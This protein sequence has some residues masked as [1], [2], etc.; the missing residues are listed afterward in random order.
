MDKKFLLAITLSLGVWILW[1][2]VFRPAPPQQPPQTAPAQQTAPAPSAPV[3]QPAAATAAVSPGLRVEQSTAASEAEVS[4]ST[5]IYD[6]TFTSRGGSIK[7]FI[8]KYN[9][10]RIE[11]VVEK[12]ALDRY[13]IKADTMLDMG[14]FQSESEFNESSPLSSAIWDMNRS[15]DNAVVFSTVLK[16]Q[17]GGGIKIEKHYSFQAGASHFNL[18]Y[19]LQ[20]IGRSPIGIPNNC[21]IVGTPDFLGPTMDFNNTY[22]SLSSIY[23]LDGSF[24]RGSQGGGL[25]SNE[26]E[27]VR[28]RGV[29]RWA[30][31]MSRYFLL[32]M[33]PQ[34]FSGTGVIHEGR[35]KSGYRTGMYVPIDPLQPGASVN[36]SFKVYVGEKNKEKLVAVDGSLRDA[37]DVNWMIEPIRD[38]LVWC[39]MKINILFGNFGWSLVI[40]SIIT[41][42]VLLPL[43]IKSTE[44]MRRMQELSPKLN[45]LK[46]K[47]K[48]KQDVLNKKI[49]DLYK[50]EKVNPMSGCLPLL[51]QMPFFFAL[52]SA[53]VN[54]IDLWKAPFIFWINDL[55]LPDTV[56]HIHGFNLNIL[57]IIMTVTTFIQQRM[58]PGADSS[59]QQ[60]LIKI[61]PLIF[62]VLFWNMPSGLIIYWIMQNVLQILH[63]LYVNKRAK[64][65]AKA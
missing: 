58:T 22:N 23:H 40:F 44:S 15:G 48:D 6:V 37:A 56:F 16:S 14:V 61:M 35:A 53:L 60:M 45:E 59:Q 28:E 3:A 27:N 10:R 42:I 33:V 31:L 32:I 46:E 21:M 20:N 52:Y 25:F 30:G 65:G 17:Q 8:Y 24:E 57:P 41:K 12:S 38:F 26:Q 34:Q 51:L 50:K 5:D 43:T 1:Y 47:Y 19:R 54:C 18:E 2:M 49:M 4:L 7:S 36:R 62:I 9:G 63:Q 13:G 39:L 29:A 11:L 64:S 55:S